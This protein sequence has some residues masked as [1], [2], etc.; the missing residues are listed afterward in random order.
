VT[1]ADT[2][3]ALR[4]ARNNGVVT[5][6]YRRGGTWETMSAAR[7]AEQATIAVGALA[8]STAGFGGQPVTVDF[9]N[10]S[11]TGTSPVC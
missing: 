4:V 7:D 10:F 9:S 5:T 6:Y 11:V 2:S 3:G 8:N 1:I